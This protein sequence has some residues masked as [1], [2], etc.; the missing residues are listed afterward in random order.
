MTDP[1]FVKTPQISMTDKFAVLTNLPEFKECDAE[2][3]AEWLPY[4]G[5]SKDCNFG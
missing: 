4:Q 1:L 2:D 3:A 5:R